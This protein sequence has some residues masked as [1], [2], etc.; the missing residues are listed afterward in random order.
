VGPELTVPPIYSPIPSAIHPS[1]AAIDA[2]TTAWAEAIGIGSDDLRGRLVQHDIG[3]FAARVLPEGRE[4]VVS[5]LA[6]FVLWLFVVDDDYCEEGELGGKPGHLLSALQRLLRVAQN[7]GT[8]MLQ[9]DPV[10][11]G[12]RDLRDRIDRYGTAAQA[13]RWVEALLQYFTAVVHEAH[14]RRARTVPSLNDY[15]LIRLYNGATTVVLPLLEM[16]HGY[17]LQQN[18]RD[19]LSVRAAAE[20]ASFIIC[21]DNDLFSHHKESRGSRYYL[22][23]LRVLEHEYQ[24]TSSQALVM[25]IAQRDRVM[26]L[27]LRLREELLDQASPELAQYLHSLSTFIRGAQDWGISSLRYTTPNDPAGLPTTFRETPT[28]ESDEPL[29]IPVISGWWELAGPAPKPR[30]TC[31]ASGIAPVHGLPQTA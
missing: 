22:N 31:G 18:E 10:A 19:H 7:P 30:T 5:L 4:G 28:D 21:W 20:M 25:A 26:R 16:G 3:S 2:Q 17:E 13:A 11:N 6:D 23:V 27:F 29:D 9:D 24:L 8:P 15:T 14:H 12:L 1:H